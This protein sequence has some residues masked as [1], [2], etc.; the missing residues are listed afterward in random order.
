MNSIGYFRVLLLIWHVFNLNLYISKIALRAICWCYTDFNL[1]GY[2]RCR[3][4]TCLDTYRYFFCMYAHVP[5]SSQKKRVTWQSTKHIICAGVLCIKN[6]NYKLYAMFFSFS[7]NISSSWPTCWCTGWIVLIACVVLVGLF[8][9]QHRGTHRVAFLFAP[10][11]V[12]W[13]LSI[14]IIGLYN[15]IH[16]NP[17][18]FVALSPHYIVKFF[19]KTGKDGWISLGGVLLAIT[20][21]FN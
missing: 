20:G 9:L 5:H 4:V 12:L 2:M 1:M 18:I 3:S 17:R 16:W 14:G 7:T 8:A 6:T 11:V 10:I 15:I 21:E 19:K 13:L